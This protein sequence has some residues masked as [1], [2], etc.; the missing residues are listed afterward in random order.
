MKRIFAC[1]IVLAWLLSLCACSNAVSTNGTD[2][3][4]T[5]PTNTIPSNSVKPTED[6]K[7]ALDVFAG[8]TVT[9]S[10]AI[11]GTGKHWTFRY[12]YSKVDYDKSNAD[13]KAFLQ[14][15]EFYSDC[16]RKDLRNGDAIT[17]NV[18]WSKTMAEALGVKLLE[19]SRDYVVSG[20][21][22]VYRSAAEVPADLEELQLIMEALQKEIAKIEGAC[23]VEYRYFYAYRSDNDAY[24][25]EGN[26]YISGVY[27]TAYVTVRDESGRQIAAYYMMGEN[28]IGYNA[29]ISQVF[30]PRIETYA[31]D[32][33]NE[34][35]VPY[36]NASEIT[37]EEFFQNKDT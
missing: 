27:V 37:L 2:P 7:V 25:Q 18:T 9:F 32:M 8:L 6:G 30:V 19:E 14:S 22:D 24:P 28:A 20:L 26:A 11:N 16:E 21:Y 5:N 17:V 29:G 23:E 34:D 4:K 12:D 10:P 15:I 1:M 33:V 31:N 36:I 35:G 3:T 13:I